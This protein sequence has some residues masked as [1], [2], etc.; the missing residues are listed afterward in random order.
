[1]RH[2]KRCSRTG[3]RIWHVTA[4]LALTLSA[5]TSV[6]APPQSSLAPPDA[7]SASP[8][9]AAASAPDTTGEA[10]RWTLDIDGALFGTYDRQ[11]GK[12]GETQ[13]RSQNWLMAMGSRQTRA[14]TITLA[15]MF[16]AEPLTVGLAGYSEILQEGEAYNHLQMTDHQHPHDLFMQLSAAW[17]IAL[18]DRSSLTVAGGPV[19]EA[20]LGPVAFMHRAS[21]AENPTAPLSHHIFDSTHV[22]TGVVM[23]RFD[24]GIV[25]VEGS[26]FRGREPD[27]DRYDIDVGALDSW[28]VRGWLHL[29]GGWTVQASHGYLHQPEELEPGDQRRTNGSISW[30]R[31]K[32]SDYSAVTVA[33]GRNARRYSVVNALL[34]EATHHVRRTSVYGRFEDTQVE[35]EILLFPEIVHRPH[36]G[37][38]VDPIRAFT[39]GAVRDIVTTRGVA[40]GIGGDVTFY[41]L[42]PLLQITHG[43]R[44]VSFHLFVR[45]CRA[46]PSERMWNETMGGQHD[47]SAMAGMAHHHR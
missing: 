37:E 23:T 16:T 9:S 1:M 26:V 22:S 8:S 38:L 7:Q 14:G 36:P 21:A 20:T 12:R 24:R 47:S 27:Q 30:F 5:R 15:G 4:L 35:T 2:I 32:G 17:R 40:A 13:V 41:G 6:A 44:P 34:A 33:I 31:L 28:A 11:G 10:R 43:V 25:S 46:T 19:G 29:G 45:L 42:P 39:A 3:A 18:G